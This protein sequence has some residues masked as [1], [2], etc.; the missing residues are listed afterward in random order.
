MQP[1]VYKIDLKSGDVLLLCTDGLTT[2]IQDSMM[3]YA[4][5]MKI[6]AKEICH[7]LVDAANQAGGVDNITLMIARF[8]QQ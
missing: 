6:N 2:H 5:R 4:L 3:A 8:L 1:E 7:H